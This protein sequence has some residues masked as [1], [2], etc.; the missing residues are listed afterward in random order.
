MSD[1]DPFLRVHNNCPDLINLEI[2]DVLG[3]KM[4][5]LR[6][7]P[8]IVDNLTWISQYRQRIEQEQQIREQDPAAADL[9]AQYQAYINLVNK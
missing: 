5:Y 6:I 4:L 8:V 1:N 9:F 3:G 2:M 7:L